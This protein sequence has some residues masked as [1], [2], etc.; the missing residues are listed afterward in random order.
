M[1]G[2]IE[3]QLGQQR[4]LIE[5]NTYVFVPAGVP[6]TYW[7]SDSDVSTHI[8]VQIPEAPRVDEKLK[9]SLDL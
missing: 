8:Q 6:H 2:R 9:I 7:N 4:H 3:F 1:T 5:P